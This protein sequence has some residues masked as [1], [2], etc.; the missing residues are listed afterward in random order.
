M[1]TRGI[2]ILRLNTKF[3]LKSFVQHDVQHNEEVLFS[4]FQLKGHTLGFHPLTQKDITILCSIID[5]STGN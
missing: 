1:L 5:S 4:R 3:I 2:S